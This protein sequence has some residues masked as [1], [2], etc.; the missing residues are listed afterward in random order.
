MKLHAWK[1]SPP[2]FRRFEVWPL[3]SS[4][5]SEAL[6]LAPDSEEARTGLEKASSLYLANIRYSQ[7]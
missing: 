1:F 7:I 5:Y 6:A 2:W 4:S 3:R